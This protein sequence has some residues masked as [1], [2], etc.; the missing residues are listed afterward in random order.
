MD[1][2]FD[3]SNAVVERRWVELFLERRRSIEEM[4]GLVPDVAFYRSEEFETLLALAHEQL[5]TTHDKEKLQMLAS[6]L[7]NSGT[8]DFRNDD[9]ELML[10]TLRDISPSDLQTL[11]NENL[12]GWLPLTKRI[13]Y[14][15]EI[16]SSLSRLASLGLVI[17]KHLR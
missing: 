10:R 1:N 14:A 9:K 12:T 15:P 16:L 4:R 17:E 2:R 6:A 5:R 8:E 7:A 3:R 11:K 13:E